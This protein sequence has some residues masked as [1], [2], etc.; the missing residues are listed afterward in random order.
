MSSTVV[1]DEDCTYWWSSS[2][3]STMSATFAGFFR[4]RPRGTFNDMSTSLSCIKKEI[5]Y[6]P[7]VI[8][9]TSQMNVYDKCEVVSKLKTWKNQVQISLE[10]F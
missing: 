8:E 2:K 6:L 10:V 1:I 7:R 4:V 3:M 9:L 5:V